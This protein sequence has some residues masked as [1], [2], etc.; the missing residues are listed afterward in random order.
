[1]PDFIWDKDVSVP[2]PRRLARL[3]LV[4]G[5]WLMTTGVIAAIALPNHRPPVRMVSVQNTGPVMAAGLT[6]T[7]VPHVPAGVE[8]IRDANPSTTRDPRVIWMT[9]TAYCS[10]PICCGKNADGV[11]ASGKKVTANYGHFVAAPA[12]FPFGTRLIIPGYNRDRP[13]PVYDRGGAIKGDCL[14]VFFPDHETA[15]KWGR[16]RIAVTV[17]PAPAVHE[18]VVTATGR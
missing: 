8:L 15:K 9:V 18:L 17:V 16:R 2:L 12:G 1:M 7:I 14:D 4:V 3:G 10:C 13:V 5:C 6:R 11:T